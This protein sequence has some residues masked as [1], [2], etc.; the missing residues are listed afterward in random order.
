MH[1]LFSYPGHVN[2]AYPFI[3]SDYFML[4]KNAI[5]SK[6]NFATLTS[7]RLKLICFLYIIVRPCVPFLLVTVLYVLPFTASDYP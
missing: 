4:K 5:K 7:C 1:L 3:F 2:Y 6:S